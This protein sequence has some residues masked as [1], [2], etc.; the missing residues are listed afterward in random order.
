MRQIQLNI[1]DTVYYVVGEDSVYSIK[2]TRIVGTQTR[3]GG[4][5]LGTNPVF[6][7]IV[8]QTEDGKL[9]NESSF[10]NKTDE[11]PA[12]QVF[13]TKADAVDYIIHCLHCEIN[14][15]WQTLLNAQKRMLQ[16]ERVLHMYERYG[17]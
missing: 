15:Q 1:G 6:E 5:R 17:K 12:S 10:R 14:A 3:S 11:L 2:K 7:Y 9:L 13:L 8:Y 4:F 16:A